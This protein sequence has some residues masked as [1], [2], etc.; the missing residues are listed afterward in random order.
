MWSCLICRDTDEN[1]TVSFSVRMHVR[2]NDAVVVVFITPK[3][4][5]F[6]P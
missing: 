5:A 3:C 1:W 6:N 4:S 2:M